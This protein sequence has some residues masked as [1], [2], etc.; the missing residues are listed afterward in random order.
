M[1]ERKVTF[2][3]RSVERSGGVCCRCTAVAMEMAAVAGRC[4]F[5]V[6]VP[7]IGLD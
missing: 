7:E 4:S 3:S 2:N 5:H 6:V 1:L